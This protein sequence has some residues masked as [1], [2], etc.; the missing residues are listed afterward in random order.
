MIRNIYKTLSVLALGGML[1]MVSCTK[2]F[3]KINTDPTSAPDVPP[4][5]KLT[6]GLIYT[7][8]G[9]YEA[10]RANI[11]YCGMMIQHFASLNLTYVGDKYLYND[12]YSGAAFNSFYPNGL[13]IITDMMTQTENDPANANYAAIAHILRVVILQRL[14]DLYGDVPYSQA[15]K[16][17]T[18]LTFYPAY[19]QQSAIYAGLA[20]ELEMAAGMLDASKASPGDADITGYRGDVTKWKKL[21]YSLMLRIGMRLSKKSDQTQA[22]TIVQKA[23]AGGVFTDRSEV[24]YIRHVDGDYDN[25]NSHVIGTYSNSR[26][27]TNKDN[28][29]IK[30]SKSFIDMLKAKGDPRLQ[31]ISELPKADSTPGGSDVPAVQKGLRNGY[32]NTSDPVY[33]IA[34]VDDA[35]LAHYSQPKQVLVLANTPNIFLT[36]SEVQLMLAEAAARGWTTGTPATYFIEGVKAGIWQYTLYSAAIAYNDV[37]A[38]TYAT[39]QSAALAGGLT[40]QLQ[41]IN[42]QYY[43]T[44]LLNEYEAYANWRR[45][46]YPVLTPVNYKNNETNGQIPRR[47]RYPRGEYNS[48][49]T[50]VNAAVAAQGADLF[51]TPIWW[52]KP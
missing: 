52:D 46:G 18:D 7:S 4:S 29:A 16:G 2:N 23:I 17:F 37:T 43:I 42:E 14:T 38:T 34:S 32:D 28:L 48:N 27:Q 10:W 40:A 50:N 20:A 1:S 22:R 21:A 12:D 30:Y 39:A 13:K 36:Y 41:A 25:P 24:F 49:G 6:R 8:G 33:G 31:I 51:T 5:I 35:N 11:I 15:S 45:T 19:D 9:E 3:E 26:G 44:T 47:L